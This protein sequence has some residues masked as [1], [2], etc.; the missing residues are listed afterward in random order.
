MVLTKIWCF[1]IDNDANGQEKAT[2]QR[3]VILEQAI[4]KY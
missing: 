4:D 2:V 3:Y 1:W